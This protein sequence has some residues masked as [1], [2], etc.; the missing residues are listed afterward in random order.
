MF[1]GWQYSYYSPFTYQQLPTQL[2]VICRE[3][4]VT[5]TISDNLQDDL[6][7]VNKLFNFLKRI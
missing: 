3:L 2:D 5:S 4:P 7:S 1:A 6:A